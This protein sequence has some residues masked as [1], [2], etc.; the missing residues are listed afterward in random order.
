MRSTSA[1]GDRVLQAVDVRAAE[2]ARA[3][4]VHDL[5]A[6]R[7]T[8]RASA[9]ATAPGAVR[10][11]VVDDQHA[12]AVV[13]EHA[14]REH[15]QVLALV[16]GR[17][18]D[19]DVQWRGHDRGRLDELPASAAADTISAGSITG[20]R[21]RSC[22]KKTRPTRIADAA[23][24]AAAIPAGVR[25]RHSRRAPATANG[26]TSRYGAT[27]ATRYLRECSAYDGPTAPRV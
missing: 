7:D 8:R 14:A 15:R 10:R 19:E 1:C 21:N 16:V 27:D 4:A 9:S 26:R 20:I 12:E 6:A 17:D 18:D 11:S 22:G 5:D 13:R 2:P 23:E 25:L 3:G 24:R